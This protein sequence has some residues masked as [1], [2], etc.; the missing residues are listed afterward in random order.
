MLLIKAIVLNHKL[1]NV[2][3][4]VDTLHLELGTILLYNKI[5]IIP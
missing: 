3:N 5:H 1:M 4:Y 2:N